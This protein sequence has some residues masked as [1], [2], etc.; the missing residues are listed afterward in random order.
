MTDSQVETDGV[1][2]T[3]RAMI[4]GVGAV[5][6]SALLAACGTDEGDGSLADGGSGATTGAPPAA[7]TQAA[8]PTSGAPEST[9]G[10]A[11]GTK[12]ASTGDIPTGGGKI[13]KDKQVVVTQPAKG[14]FKA[15]KTV[16][17]HQGCDVTTVKSGTINCP[18]HGSQFSVQDGSVKSGPATKGLTAV[19][20]KVNGG[21]VWLT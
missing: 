7:T 15:F 16:C 6:A 14:T 18:C 12:L 5:G 2:T 3:R 17:P 13:F 9:G 4:A 19:T 11:E 20:V 8:A 1:T 10:A 21:S